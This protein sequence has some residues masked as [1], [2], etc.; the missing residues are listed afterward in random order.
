MG[1]KEAKQALEVAKSLSIARHG[2]LNEESIADELA[3]L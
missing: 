2:K 3:K 1:E